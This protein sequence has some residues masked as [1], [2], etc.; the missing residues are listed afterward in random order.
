M[1]MHDRA[2]KALTNTVVCGEGG[3]RDAPSGMAG[4]NRRDLQRRQLRSAAALAASQA[5]GVHARGIT[6]TARTPLG[7]QARC[8]TVAP[9]VASLPMAV[10]N[11]RFVR[12]Q[13]E[14]RGIETRGIVAAGAVVQDVQAIGDGADQKHPGETVRAYVVPI[15]VSLPV[16]NGYS[17][18]AT[19]SRT[20]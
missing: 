19:T 6:L 2:D 17:L 14:M 18:P 12:A 11:V 7:V 8:V 1:A 13:P 20:G 10:R 5:L 3:L 15:R 9:R 16:P 4:T